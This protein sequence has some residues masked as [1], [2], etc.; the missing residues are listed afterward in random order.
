MITEDEIIQQCSRNGVV[1]DTEL[2]L[3]ICVGLH[4]DNLLSSFKKTQTYDSQDYGILLSILNLAK[5]RYVSPQVLAE[6]TNHADMIKQPAR[7]AVFE[8][9]RKLMS[10]YLE[11]YLP[12]E[13][14]LSD[15]SFPRV[16]FT[17]TSILCISRDK[18][19]VVFT[20]DFKLAGIGQSRGLPVINY[21]NIQGQGWFS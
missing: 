9:I 14:L 18:L 4:S 13:R 11:L 8:I 19:S 21:R 16:G 20:S 2:L 3:V 6:L 1:L 5:H 7:Q 12:M 10:E 17:D 15:R